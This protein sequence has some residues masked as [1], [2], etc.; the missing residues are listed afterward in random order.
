VVMVAVVVTTAASGDWCSGVGGVLT[1]GVVV[2]TKA[3]VA[4][5]RY[6]SIFRRDS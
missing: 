2:A 6:Y 3:T 1:T 4:V 5:V